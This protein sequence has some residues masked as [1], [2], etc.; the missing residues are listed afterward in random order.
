VSGK[1]GDEDIETEFFEEY[2]TM[3]ERY[4]VARTEKMDKAKVQRS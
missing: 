2:F 4:P 3:N 1:T